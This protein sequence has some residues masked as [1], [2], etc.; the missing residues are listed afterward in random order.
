V[1]GQLGIDKVVELAR[2]ATME[3]ESDLVAWVRGVSVGSVRRKADVTV[4]QVIEDARDAQASRSSR[5]GIST[6]EGGSGWRL[7]SLRPKERRW[8]GHSSISPT[9]SR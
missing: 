5:G 2:F 9:S 6:M 1:R 8:P 4:R 3:T 7:S